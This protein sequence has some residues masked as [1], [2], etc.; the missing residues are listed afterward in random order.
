MFFHITA[1]TI[2]DNKIAHNMRSLVYNAHTNT[3][4]L[5]NNLN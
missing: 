5:I 1:E 4:I 2:Q 3:I